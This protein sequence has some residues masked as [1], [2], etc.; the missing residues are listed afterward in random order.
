[1]VLKDGCWL[2]WCVEGGIVEGGGGREVGGG[3]RETGEAVVVKM[4][5][6]D[7][8]G[9]DGDDM[10]VLIAVVVMTGGDGVLV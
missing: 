1:M 10:T 4:T 3:E 9:V 6:S 2:W 8:G 5:G 7:E